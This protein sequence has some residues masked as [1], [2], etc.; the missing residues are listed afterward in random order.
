MPLEALD[1]VPGALLSIEKLVDRDRED[2]FEVV[3]RLSGH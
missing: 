1:F 3:P 2:F